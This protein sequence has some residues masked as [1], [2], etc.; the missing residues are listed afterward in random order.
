MYLGFQMQIKDLD[1]VKLYV[2]KCIDCQLK[3]SYEKGAF[4]LRFI[5]YRAV[6]SEKR[7]GMGSASV[8]IL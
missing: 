8:E 5:H 3:I 7:N 4:C 1:F 6:E 2:S